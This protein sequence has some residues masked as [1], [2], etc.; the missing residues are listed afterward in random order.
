[1]LVSKPQPQQDQLLILGLRQMDQVGTFFKRTDQALCRG[2]CNQA[3][4]AVVVVRLLHGL[5]REDMTWHF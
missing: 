2:S 3:A 5:F 1:M 4:A